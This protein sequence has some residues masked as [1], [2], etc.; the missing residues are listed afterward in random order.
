MSKSLVIEDRGSMIEQYEALAHDGASSASK[1]RG[2]T[3]L[4]RKNEFMYNQTF[5]A[6]W[7]Q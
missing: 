3:K 5:P 6:G 4:R 1:E 7:M 2:G